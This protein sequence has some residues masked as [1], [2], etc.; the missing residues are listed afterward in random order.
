MRSFTTGEYREKR[1]A[2]GAVTFEHDGRTVTAY[3]PTPAQY[4]LFRSAYET[5]DGDVQEIADVVNFF[6][7]LFDADDHD[8]F[9]ARLFD[10][11]DPF[12][13]GG[14]SGMA[15]V[16]ATLLVVWAAADTPPD[17]D[18]LSH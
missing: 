10:P 4:A 7:C 13:F 5:Y 6:F 18:A 8:Y 14:E 3:P 12:D 2:E 9:K 17:E 11:N 1:I 15:S 16:I